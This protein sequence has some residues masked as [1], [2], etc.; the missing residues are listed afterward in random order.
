MTE[1]DR[2]GVTERDREGVTERDREG[3]TERDRECLLLAC[4]TSQQHHRIS[5]DG[6][7]QTSVRAATLR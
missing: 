5:E 7:A 4:S 3:V 2:E 6:S 1:R